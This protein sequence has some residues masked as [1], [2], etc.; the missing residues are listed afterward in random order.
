M[1]TH[2]ASLLCMLT[3]S[4][5]LTYRVS[6]NSVASPNYSSDFRPGA[7][8]HV[9]ETNEGED[10]FRAEVAKKIR[11]LMRER[12]YVSATADQA[13]FVLMFGYAISSHSE[14]QTVYVP[15]SSKPSTPPP[16][17][18]SF[19]EAFA[20]GM[21]EGLKNRTPQQKQTKVNDRSLRLAVI[22]ARHLRETGET[23]TVWQ[24]DTTSSGSSDDLRDVLNYMLVP[25]FRHFGKDTGKAVLYKID[26]HD[27]SVTALRRLP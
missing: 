23:R 15:D 4:S 13:D 3:L 16:A 18:A 7:S 27:T 25:T 11:R 9:Y 5:C 1:R 10:L 12:G 26:E 14:T 8:I 22:D 19:A 2:I 20:H 6:V 24:C 21:A 17:G